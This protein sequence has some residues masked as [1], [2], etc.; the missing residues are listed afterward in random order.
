[1]PRCHVSASLVCMKRP[2]LP[3]LHGP[4]PPLPAPPSHHSL[5]TARLPDLPLPGS[6]LPYLQPQVYNAYSQ[7]MIIPQS[8]VDLTQPVNEFAHKVKEFDQPREG[9][10][11]AVRHLLQ[12][13]LPTWVRPQPQQQQ[14]GGAAAT[15]AAAAEPEALPVP[16]SSKPPLAGIK[17]ASD[18]SDGNSGQAAKRPQTGAAPAAAA[19]AAAEPA[20]RTTSGLQVED[21]QQQSEEG[22]EQEVDAPATA[23]AAAAASVPVPQL[24]LLL[25]LLLAGCF[26]ACTFDM[27]GTL[28]QHAAALFCPPRCPAGCRHSS[29]RS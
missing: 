2:S 14:N 29:G 1:M 17:R 5:P 7:S 26:S 16:G 8:K 21:I 4:L 22:Q 15:T 19:A 3:A 12:R 27:S 11:I 25:C 23:A 6:T 13:Q 18:S 20:S 9:Q 28:L 24:T 10:D